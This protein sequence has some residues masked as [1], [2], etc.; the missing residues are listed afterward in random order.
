MLGQTYG[1]AVGAPEKSL[2]A[3][4]EEEVK[5]Y[6]EAT[7]LALAEDPLSWWKSHE[8][9]YPSMAKLAK[10]YLCIPGTSVPSESSRRLETSSQRSTLTS[11]HVHQLLFLNKNADIPSLSKC[12]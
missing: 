3:I 4:V 5:R 1:D 9:M 6:Q 2:S 12:V 10:R 8:E 11:E 7:P